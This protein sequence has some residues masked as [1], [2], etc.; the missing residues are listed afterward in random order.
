MMTSELDNFAK[1]PPTLSLGHPLMVT[2][3]WSS[4]T[5][6]FSSSPL[7]LK[8]GPRISVPQNK[9]SIDIAP[10]LEP[11]SVSPL[12]SKLALIYLLESANVTWVF[13]A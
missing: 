6:Q 2:L 5:Y 7:L 12:I 3:H 10:E 1:H 4:L 9:P 11:N 8:L 13:L